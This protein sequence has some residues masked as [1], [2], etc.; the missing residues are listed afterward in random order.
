MP[1]LLVVVT[2]DL[3]EPKYGLWRKASASPAWNRFVVNDGPPQCLSVEVGDDGQRVV[4]L[5]HPV[6]PRDIVRQQQ[7]TTK[8]LSSLLS[9][10]RLTNYDKVHLVVHRGRENWKELERRFPDRIG[11]KAIFDHSEQPDPVV[12]PVFAA[13]VQFFETPSLESFRLVVQACPAS[14]RVDNAKR[15][16][17]L[18]HDIGNLLRPFEIELQG[19]SNAGFDLFYWDEIAEAW[20]G[21]KLALKLEHVRSL[22]YDGDGENDSVERVLREAGKL[23]IGPADECIALWKTIQQLIPKAEDAIE[24][25][26][27]RSLYNNAAALGQLV[28]SGDGDRVRKILESGQCNSF[29]QWFAELIDSL[30]RLAKAVS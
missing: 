22:V 10:R 16:R 19:W 1:E 3:E 7:K 15:I 20:S 23:E 5:C 27:K 28:Q 11:G 14:E 8:W 29:K 26:S 9:D 12:D 30:D 17:W 24:D 21:E 18:K 13:L 2:C 6:K 4:V 25:S